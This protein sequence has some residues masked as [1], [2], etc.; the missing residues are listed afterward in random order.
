M[1]ASLQDNS[2]PGQECICTHGSQTADHFIFDCDRLEKERTKLIAYR[3][4][5]EDWPVRKCD[6]VNR[7]LKQF[8]AFTDSIDFEK[9]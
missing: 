9:L 6:L 2:V 8:T 4:K 7:Y 1:P 3:A 5:E